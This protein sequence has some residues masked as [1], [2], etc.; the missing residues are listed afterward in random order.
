MDRREAQGGPKRPQGKLKAFRIP[1]GGLTGQ[2]CREVLQFWE[3]GTAARGPTSQNCREVCKFLG[4]ASGHG[5]YCVRRGGVEGC[6]LIWSSDWRDRPPPAA[7][8]LCVIATQGHCVIATQGH[9]CLC[10]TQK[11][12]LFYREAHCLGQK[13]AQNPRW[14][15]ISCRATVLS[16]WTGEIDATGLPEPLGL[17]LDPNNGQNNFFFAPLAPCWGAALQGSLHWF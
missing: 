10:A 8:R 1:A 16:I 2:K 13:L 9:C 14:A 15:Q 17:F 5:R 3:W 4:R 7:R 11:L 12:S 6:I